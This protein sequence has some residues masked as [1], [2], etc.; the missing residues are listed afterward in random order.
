[1]PEYVYFLLP[2]LENQQKKKDEWEE[3]ITEFGIL[4]EEWV[5]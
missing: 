2:V 4:E 5:P 3:K 1:M